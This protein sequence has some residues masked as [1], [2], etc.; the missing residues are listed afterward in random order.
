ME[1]IVRLCELPA[2]CVIGAGSGPSHVIG[3]NSEVMETLRYC[4]QSSQYKIC[5]TDMI[6]I[7]LNVL[8][9]TQALE[10]SFMCSCIRY[11]S[12]GL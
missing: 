4:Y 11:F 6:C 12:N 10:T 3:V 9:L 7:N 5:N 1:D 8:K 2:A